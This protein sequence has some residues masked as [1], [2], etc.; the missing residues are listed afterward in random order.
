[1]NP[2]HDNN[3]QLMIIIFML[4]HNYAIVLLQVKTPTVYYTEAPEPVF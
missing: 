1:M 4:L 2:G 3:L